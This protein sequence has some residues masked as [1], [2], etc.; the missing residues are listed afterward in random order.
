MSKELT[1]VVDEL[2]REK[3]ISRDILCDA[4]REAI[5]AAV[6]RKIGKLLE[7]DVVVDI[8]R[9]I[10]EILLPKEVCEGV[11]EKWT[12][13]YIDDAQQYKENAQLG[14]V[15]MVPT[16]LEELGRQ[17]A[18][19]AKQKLFEK[20]R[21][22]EKQVVLDQFQDRVGDVVNGVVLKTDR[23][24]LIINIGKTEAVLPKREMINGDFYNRGDYVR[25]LLLDIKI[26]KGWPQLI[27]SR[28]HPQ[29]LKKLFEVEIPEVYEGIIDVKAV[30]REPGDRAKVAVYTMNSSIDPV[31]ACIGLKGV[32]INAISNELRGEKIDVIEWSPDPI[33]FVCNAISPAEVVLTNVFED[34]DTIEIVVP[35][36]Q[37]SL[38][39]GKKGQNVRLAAKLSEWRLDV[40]KESE[41]AEIRKERM[42][43]QEQELKE[44]YEI[45][46]LENLS[47]L[48]A[49][50]VGKLIEAGLDDIE[51]L[52][53]ASPHE[54]ADAVSK[55]EDEAVNIINAAID[56]LASKFEDMDS[57]EN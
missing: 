10:I 22:A 46:N 47:V 14:D 43:D 16:T 21:E 4:L 39:I 3:G 45:Y 6:A 11:D 40:L 42:Q 20:I 51:K 27:L 56:F 50:E 54:V 5:L 34:E 8:D 7:P 28:T 33:K 36:D 52:S 53:N 15:I 30:S 9:G 2:G 57:E 37:L 1:K 23:D 44:F 17:A 32:R 29:F 49:D 31:G 24:N 38:A 48:S 41:Y 12:E 19:V 18:L 55:G 25:A 35:D 26:V 13:I